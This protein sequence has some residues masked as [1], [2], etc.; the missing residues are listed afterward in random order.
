[1]LIRNYF[2]LLMKVVKYNGIRGTLKSIIFNLKYFPLRQALKL[3]V[4]MTSR[5]K[6][7]N[8]RR[9]GIVLKNCGGGG[10]FGMLRFG[11]IDR[12]YC[13]D[14]DS[15]INILGTLILDG[16]GWRCFASGAIIYIGEG[17]EM[18]IGKSFSSS[19]DTK[20]YCRHKITIGDNNMWSYYN[21]IMDNDA[22]FIYDFE[23]NHINPNKEV[24]FGENVW[25]GCRCTVL[26]GSLV[27]DG[28][29]IGSC[30][31]VCKNLASKNSIYAGL[32]PRFIRK[33]VKWDRKLI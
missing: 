9:N 14:H 5:V 28:S 4:I 7:R 10:I 1:M 27:P 22:H 29:I 25:M 32:G 26:K 19:H 16:S 24:V 33:E 31:V 23:G 12:E 21:V 2:I 3:P 15:V 17:A 6:V 8:M 18:T 13:Y 30:S 11:G 20:I